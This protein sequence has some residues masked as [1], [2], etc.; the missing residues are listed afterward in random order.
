MV[1]HT[2]HTNPKHFFFCFK[3]IVQK[4]AY[5]IIIIWSL[6]TFLS[7]MELLYPMGGIS[8]HFKFWPKVKS[9]IF[10]RQYLHENHN[11]MRH[12]FILFCKLRKD[13]SYL[14]IFRVELPWSPTS[15]L[16]PLPKKSGLF[17]LVTLGSETVTSYFTFT[18]IS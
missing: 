4:F 2:S 14:W 16:C 17:I 10:H 9:F 5:K 15:P 6:Y 8:H 3:S 12:N 13:S 1:C 7:C 18:Y 11:H